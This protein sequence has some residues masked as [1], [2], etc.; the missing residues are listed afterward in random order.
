AEFYQS[1]LE[2]AR[3]IDDLT[4][5][6]A[7]RVQEALGD[8]RR[9]AGDFRAA[10]AAYRAARRTDADRVSEARLSLKEAWVAERLDRYA[11]ALRWVR[12]GTKALVDVSGEEAARQR[13]ELAVWEAVFRQ[14]QGHS[15]EAIRLCERAIGEGEAVGHRRVLARAYHTLDW[16]YQTLGRLDSGY[17]E[18]AL[19]IYEEL[20]DLAGQAISLNNLGIAAFM[21]G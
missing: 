17:G 11:D 10:R 18:K 5:D 2:A 7:G 19:Q 8:V 4:P 13:A 16:A 9:V 12:R 20:G 3:K 14:A 6:E 21:A 15:R 1:A